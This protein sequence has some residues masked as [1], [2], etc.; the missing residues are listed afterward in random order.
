ERGAAEFALRL[1][2]PAQTWYNYER[3][4]TVPAEVVLSV[5]E[6]TLVLPCWLLRGQGE[7]YESRKLRPVSDP[8]AAAHPRTALVEQVSDSVE[9][10]SLCI[11]LWREQSE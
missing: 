5:I 7:K 9:P 1:G 2:V 4:V 3:G 6:H 10:H 8:R 11:K